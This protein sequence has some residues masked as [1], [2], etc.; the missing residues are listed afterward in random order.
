MHASR[1]ILIG[2]AA[3]AFMA[4]GFVV[5]QVSIEGQ[6]AQITSALNAKNTIQCPLPPKQTER[7]V[8]TVEDLLFVEYQIQ[9][10][11]EDLSKEIESF[12]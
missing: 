11:G 3:F 9:N 6:M 10:S 12:Q 5:S 2:L 4:F 7:R 1:N 8:E